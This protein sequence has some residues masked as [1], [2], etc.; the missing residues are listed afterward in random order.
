MTRTMMIHIALVGGGEGICSGGQVNVGPWGKSWLLNWVG[1]WGGGLSLGGVT[2]PT[3]N[4][5][6]L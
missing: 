2:L 1:I 3:G 4:I 5:T 6:P